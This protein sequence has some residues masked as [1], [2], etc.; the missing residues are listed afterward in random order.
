MLLNDGALGIIE[1]LI[2]VLET[3]M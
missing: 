2:S 3:N 1:I